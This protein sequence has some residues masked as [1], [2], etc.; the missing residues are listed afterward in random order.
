MTTVGLSPPGTDSVLQVEPTATIS[1]SGLASFTMRGV[2][3]VFSC[4]L[5]LPLLI[6]FSDQINS[7]FNVRSN[8]GTEAATRCPPKRSLSS[9][10]V[11]SWPLSAAVLAA[12]M[13][14]IPPPI[15]I[16]FFFVAAGVI[17]KAASL[18]TAGF[19]SHRKGLPWPI[20]LVQPS[21][22]NMQGLMSS[23]LLLA[24]LL[25]SSGSASRPRPKAIRSALPSCSA[26]SLISILSAPT[27]MIGTFL[28][29]RLMPSAKWR[30]CPRP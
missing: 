3:S 28:I 7:S 14:A 9:T 19:T 6:C 8:F 23:T 12:S 24:S 22:P 13:P 16:T 2:A 18:P 17:L 15:T 26:L 1:T 27:A 10:R 20:L 21:L 25:A 4:I 11:T 5:I 30:R 29:V